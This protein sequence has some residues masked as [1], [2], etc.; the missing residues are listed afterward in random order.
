MKVAVASTDGKVVNDHFGRA[1]AFYIFELEKDRI[2][3]IEKRETAPSCPTYT[4]GEGVPEG[5]QDA[6][7]TVAD[8]AAV[9]VA[10]IGA[11]AIRRL[12]KRNIT[13]LVLPLVLEEA[14]EAA[15]NEL[16]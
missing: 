1:K 4:G 8:C 6:V 3:Y 12:E 2:T 11:G 7:D 15:R 13:A 10:Q 9:V 14:L 5:S 16:L